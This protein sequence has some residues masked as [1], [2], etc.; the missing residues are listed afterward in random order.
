MNRTY[1]SSVSE[2]HVL[3]NHST[4]TQLARQ[5]LGIRNVISPSEEVPPKVLKSWR[6]RPLRKGTAERFLNLNASPRIQSLL[7]PSAAHAGETGL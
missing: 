7:A 4:A 6:T 3:G 1:H 5:L 2:R